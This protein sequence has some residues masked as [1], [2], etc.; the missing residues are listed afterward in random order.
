MKRALYLS[1]LLLVALF[2]AA[3]GQALP[4][5]TPTPSSTLPPIRPAPSFTVY[6][7]DLGNGPATLVVAAEDH[8]TILIDR[9][10]SQ[11]LLFESLDAVGVTDLDAI[12]I[13]HADVNRLGELNEIGR[14]YGTRRAYFI[15][16]IGITDVYWHF[17]LWGPHSILQGVGSVSFGPLDLIV[18]S[19]R[20]HSDDSS[21]DSFVLEMACGDV[22]VLF[23]AGGTA[24]SERQMLAAGILRDIDVLIVAHKGSSSYPS[25]PFLNETKPEVAVI[26]AGGDDQDVHAYQEVVDRLESIGAKVWLMDTGAG[27]DIVQLTSDCNTYHVKVL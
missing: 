27:N 9:G 22:A 8:G 23:A 16:E 13:T 19:P 7:L 4:T 26:S 3:C 12:L 25:S 20:G 14:A 5:P 1:T 21:T 17:M 10:G 24:Q 6:L 2:L 11:S 15:D 18:L